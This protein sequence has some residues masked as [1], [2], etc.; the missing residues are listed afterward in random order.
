MENDFKLNL[1]NYTNSEFYI[2]FLGSNLEELN[3][4][5]NITNISIFSEVQNNSIY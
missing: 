2:Y 5:K 1:S 3:Y 4:C